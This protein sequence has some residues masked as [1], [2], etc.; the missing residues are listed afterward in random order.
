MRFE[1]KVV[2]ATGGAGGIGRASASLFAREGARVIVADIDASR[3]E[4]A[5]AAI[6]TDGGEATFTRVD[7]T[8]Y[9]SVASL[10]AT[11]MDTY[12]R[13]D[14]MFNNAGI[15][16]DGAHPLLDMPLEDYH[17]SVRV[18]QDGV[19]YGI[20][21]AGR[22]MRETG[23]VIV[24]TASIYAYIADR[25]Q[26]PYHATKGAVVAM[27]K[28]AALDLARYNIRVVAIAPG[29]IDT[30]LVDRWREDERVWETLKRSHMRG[31][32]GTPEQV[33]EVVGFLASDA[34]SFVNGQVFFVDDGAASFKR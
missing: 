32:F 25:R 33:A 29:M 10:V 12:G 22:A 4:Q 24:N 15:F 31:E 26:L 16:G 34:A 19:F 11:A 21:A 30:P 13:L 17:R 1:E 9:E 23:G 14:V 6:R 2:I 27:T 28:A 20:R 18:N 8:D 5:A 7:V 3:G